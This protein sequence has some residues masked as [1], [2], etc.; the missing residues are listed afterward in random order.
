MEFNNRVDF[1][2]KKGK[3]IFGGEM[4]NGR[5]WAWRWTMKSHGDSYGQGHG[6]GSYSSRDMN[7][8]L[9]G[10]LAWAER[11]KLPLS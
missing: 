1:D 8:E 2:G 5:L 9:T 10:V 3:S 4:C 11:Q 6:Q 7:R